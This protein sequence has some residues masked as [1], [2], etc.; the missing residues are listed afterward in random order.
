MDELE[1]ASPLFPYRIFRG[2]FALGD[3]FSRAQGR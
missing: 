2:R 3:L 1:N